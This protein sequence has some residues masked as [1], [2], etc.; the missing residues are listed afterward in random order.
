M[1]RTQRSALTWLTG[2]VLAAVV[3]TWAGDAALSALAVPA[4]APQQTAAPGI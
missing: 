1:T 2:A 3:I 4:P